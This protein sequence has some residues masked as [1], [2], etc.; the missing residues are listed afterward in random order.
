MSSCTFCAILE[1][2][3]PASLIRQDEH[4]AAFMDIQPVN[5]DHVLVVPRRH[6][7]SLAEMDPDDG[8]ATFGMAQRIAAALYRSGIR[9]EGVNF[10][11]AD[12]VAAGQEVFH[13][14]LHVIP[15]FTGDGFG[16]R[17]GPRYGNR[18]PRAD[19]DELAQRIAGSLAA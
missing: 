17:F 8:T 11:L 15:R 10:F 1:G 7:A 2:E 19:L 14:H 16:L 4:C 5:K 18:P 3:L 9:C 13:V 6:A 12:G